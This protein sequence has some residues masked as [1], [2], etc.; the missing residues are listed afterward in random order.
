M[1]DFH[2]SQGKQFDLKVS[3]RL[4]QTAYKDGKEVR[5]RCQHHWQLWKC[6]YHRRHLLPNRPLTQSHGEPDMLNP[7]HRARQTDRQTDKK[8]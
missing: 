7:K 4:G 1:K 5:E 2:S 6:Y 3:K 8:N